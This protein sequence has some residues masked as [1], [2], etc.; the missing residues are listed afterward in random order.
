M[1][2]SVGR[3]LKLPLYFALVAANFDNTVVAHATTVPR[4]S[5]G[6]PSYM[7]QTRHLE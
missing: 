7:H 1:P 6:V 5:D 4:L 2:V 3:G